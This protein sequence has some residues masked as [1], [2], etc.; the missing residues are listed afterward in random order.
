MARLIRSG[1]PREALVAK[2]TPDPKVMIGVAVGQHYQICLNSAQNVNH[3]RMAAAMD[4]PRQDLKSHVTGSPDAR[5]LPRYYVW[6]FEWIV[7]RD[8]AQ[9]PRPDTVV[10]SCTSRLRRPAVGKG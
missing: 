10:P 2:D 8:M 5:P 4:I 7:S 6:R 1:K 9:S 3:S